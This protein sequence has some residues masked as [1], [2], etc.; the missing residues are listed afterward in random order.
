MTI[1]RVGGAAAAANTVTLPAHLPGDLILIYAYRGNAAAPSPAL[2]DGWVSLRDGGSG[3]NGDRIGFKIAATNAE[4]SGAW[5]GATATIALIYR[6]TG[7]WRKPTWSALGNLVDAA[8][9]SYPDLPQPVDGWF[10]RFAGNPAATNMQATTPDG[11]TATAG[12]DSGVR[13]MDTSGPAVAE[14][15]ELVGG[16]EQ[17]VDTAVMWRTATIGLSE[18]T[19]PASGTPARD[20]WDKIPTEATVLTLSGT[21]F[22]LSNDMPDTLQGMFGN[23][24]YELQQVKYP[25]SQKATS[26]ADGVTNLNTA[27]AAVAGPI[28][29][30]GHDQGAQVCAHWM[31]EHALDVDAPDPA[32]L[33]F[34]LTGN[35]LR[36]N[37]AGSLLGAALAD[38]SVGAPT[39][40]DTPWPI[41]DVARRYDGCADWPVDQT[42]DVAVRNA[43]E[44]K[45]ALHSS[46]NVVDIYD[47]THTVWT[48]GNTTYVLTA[49]RVLPLL[50]KWDSPAAVVS[51][52]RAKV[53]EAYA[54]TRP[55]TD[56]YIDVATT[57]NVFWN[58]V[59]ANLGV[60]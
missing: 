44:G 26:I 10:V 46:Y 6:C 49:E 47:P 48:E 25:A 32:D 9:M 33:M 14:R 41:V 39:P 15:A 34:I 2:P 3:N 58:A 42:S 18:A 56:P 23:A 22:N 45:V 16:N 1:S 19:E 21:T 36:S 27:L 35:P 11:W 57:R 12:L 50:R 29:V 7:R 8:T 20:V 17:N 55:D 13:S 31:T 37:G 40:T 52:T 54:G 53:E 28:I 43:R 30:V 38:G 4:V 24:P 59:L 51:A 60:Q 5:T